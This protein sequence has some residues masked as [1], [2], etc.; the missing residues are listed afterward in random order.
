MSNESKKSLNIN[1][2]EIVES[3]EKRQYHIGLAPGE[4]ENTVLLV[5]DPKRAEKIAK[6]FDSIRISKSNR[7]FVTFTGT[8]KSLPITVMSTGIGCSNVEIAVIELSR[9]FEETDESP[10][11]LRVGTS[12]SL[13]QNILIGDLVI[14][15]AAVRLEDTS[16]N[17]VDMSYPAIAH[18]EV[19]T[20][21]IASAERKKYPYH[22]GITATASGFYG[23]QGRD[24]E[25]F[26]TKNPDLPDRLGKLNVLNFE[27]ESSTLFT[28][29]SLAKFKAGTICAIFANRQTK[30]FITDEKKHAAEQQAIECGLEAVLILKKME[31][32]KKVGKIRYW[33]PDL[34]LR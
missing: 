28:L 10:V 2:S 27:M 11:L 13:Q 23:A 8:Y 7:E 29:A 16:T 17:F 5:G 26:P 6:Y 18:F 14:S 3:S 31:Q 12:G 22:V 15:T 33:N 32:E 25:K 1:N 24:L 34:S 4:V 20:A 19:V 21:L 30:T 9:I